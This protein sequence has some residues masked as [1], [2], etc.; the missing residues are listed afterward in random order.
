MFRWSGCFCTGVGYGRHASR[1]GTHSR[2]QAWATGRLP[3][4]TGS[5]FLHRRGVREA[6][7]PYGDSFPLAQLL[8]DESSHH[9]LSSIILVCSVVVSPS[10]EFQCCLIW[11]PLRAGILRTE[12]R[13]TI[14]TLRTTLKFGARERA[15]NKLQSLETFAPFVSLLGVVRTI[16]QHLSGFVP[17]PPVFAFYHLS[18]CFSVFTT[19]PPALK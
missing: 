19:T 18:V 10:P 13:T 3:S 9:L 1:T 5:L 2:W 16:V 8:L 6:C 4:R 11:E 12:V 14:P 7:L 15:M 17:P